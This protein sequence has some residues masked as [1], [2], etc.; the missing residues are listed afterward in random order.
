[1]HDLALSFRRLFTNTLS[2]SKAG[3]LPADATSHDF[4]LPWLS[5][6]YNS[7]TSISQHH[8]LMPQGRPPT[9]GARSK[10]K[11]SPDGAS[12]STALISGGNDSGH[13]VPS[14]LQQTCLNI[15]RDALK[16][17]ELDSTVVQEVKGD[18]YNRDFAAAFGKEENLRVYAARWSPSRALGY[19]QVLVDIQDHL[20]T[21]WTS[22]DPSGDED[23]KFKAVCLGGGAG[24]ELVA[25]S[26]WTSLVLQNSS[27]FKVDA[28]FLD[29]AAWGTTVTELHRRITTAPEVSKFASAAAKEANRPLLPEDTITAH[30]DQQDALHWPQDSLQE[31]VA[32]VDLVTLMFTLNELYSIS[33]SQTQNLLLK[34][35][36]A[37]KPG[38]LLLV[39]DSPGSYS[40]VSINGAEKKY[41]MQWL[42]D[43]TLLGPPGKTP[44]NDRKWEK[45]EEDESRWFRLPQGLKYPIELENMRYQI[46]LYR[47]VGV[48]EGG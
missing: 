14:Q 31:A 42:L 24:A 20:L 10:P 8:Y 12:K 45:I 36:K 5:Y 13:R 16:P 35:T 1:M 46:H 17:D 32:D 3:V 30:F 6:Q 48:K 7:C 21:G 22:G 2:Q 43:L 33:I 28:R 19:L 44:E 38:A 47:R 34:L 23:A 39:V 27:R 37:M 25:L 11:A 18:L 4:K 15:F 40:T 9:K 26:G 41:P 29:I